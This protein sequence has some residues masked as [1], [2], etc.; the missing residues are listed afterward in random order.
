MNLT[1]PSG[2][3]GSPDGSFPGVKTLV[4]PFGAIRDAKQMRALWLVEF[5]WEAKKNF[6]NF[7][8]LCRLMMLS[9]GKRIR[10]DTRMHN[11]RL[12]HLNSEARANH[13]TAPL[14]PFINCVP[15]RLRS[16]ALL[17]PVRD[18]SKASTS[19][20]DIPKAYADHMIVY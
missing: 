15:G 12:Y 9:T 17:H 5:R 3:A 16:A 4:N 6:L 13:A 1:P 20:A 14:L 10:P 11:Q 19:P 7:H 18:F 8:N 2:R